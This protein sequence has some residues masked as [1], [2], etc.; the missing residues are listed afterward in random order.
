MENIKDTQVRI[1][2]IGDIKGYLNVE[3]EAVFPLTAKSKVTG[4]VIPLMVKSAVTV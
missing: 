1:Q 3:K 4:L 2:L